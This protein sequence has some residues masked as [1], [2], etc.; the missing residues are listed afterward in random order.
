M[1]LTPKQIMTRVEYNAAGL[2]RIATRNLTNVLEIVEPDPTWPQQFEQIKARIKNAL[3]DTAVNIAHV[4]STSVPGLAAKNIIDID[5]TVKDIL[6]EDS[7]VG[8]LE[9]AGFMFLLRERPWHEHRFFGLGR[10]PT[11]VNLHVWGPDCPE[12]ERHRI[13]REWLVNNPADRQKYAE[14][15]RAAVKETREKGEA[16]MAYT[17][18][19][20]AVVEEI[21][22]KAFR[23]LGYIE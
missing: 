4:G 23:A 9:S 19:K 11:P 20:D 22:N 13:F 10:E 6:D 16:V 5:L 14:V 3:G 21:L 7:Y 1:P 15:K 18:R 17:D 8:P 2:E 12:A